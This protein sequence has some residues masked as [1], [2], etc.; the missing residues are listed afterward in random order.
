MLLP[1]RKIKEINL[2]MLL[3]T[4]KKSLFFWHMK[5]IS[6]LCGKNLYFV[7][8]KSNGTRGLILDFSSTTILD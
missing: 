5:N 8:V 1:Y 3:F 7:N 4:E 2:L 6:T